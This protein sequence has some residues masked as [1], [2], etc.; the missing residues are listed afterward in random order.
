[1]LQKQI[2]VEIFVEES[3]IQLYQHHIRLNPQQDG[4]NTI[5]I[6]IRTRIMF[7]PHQ[8]NFGLSLHPAETAK[9]KQTKYQTF[10]D[11]GEFTPLK[12]YAEQN[13]DN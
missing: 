6:E 1:M 13:T 7:R 11:F 12:S 8:A 3:R 10:F 4:I 2:K 5:T 9:N